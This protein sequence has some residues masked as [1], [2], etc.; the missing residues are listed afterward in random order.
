MCQNQ[1][2]DM[3]H[4]VK[5]SWLQPTRQEQEEW[6]HA[7]RCALSNGGDNKALQGV[8]HTPQTLGTD[9]ALDAKGSGGSAYSSRPFSRSGGA[10]TAVRQRGRG[11]GTV[12]LLMLEPLK[13]SKIVQL[14]KQHCIRYNIIPNKI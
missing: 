1:Y 13:Y 3:E 5:E 12:S 14:I 8:K 6:Q 10:E 9:D 2:S 7:M 11:A 4:A